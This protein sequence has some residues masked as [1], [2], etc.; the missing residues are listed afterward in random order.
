MKI[1][2]DRCVFEASLVN[3]SN[4]CAVRTVAIT[5]KTDYREVWN[6]FRD[7]GRK[8]NRGTPAGITVAALN[9]LGYAVK[10]PLSGEIVPCD[11][12][13][14]SWVLEFEPLGKRK[15]FTLKS[16]MDVVNPRKIY[17]AVTRNHIAAI[18]NGEMEDIYKGRRFHVVALWEIE[19]IER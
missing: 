14:D 6:L 1:T 3:E 11:A 12:V 8:N 9:K 19:K 7:L 15:S 2:Y 18:V 16:I 17:T 4:D 10:L 13:D 5:T